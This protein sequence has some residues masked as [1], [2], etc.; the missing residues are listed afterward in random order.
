MSA[1]LVEVIARYNRI[2]ILVDANLLLLYFV[3]QLDPDL[4]SRFKRT[5]QFSREDFALLTLLLHRFSKI[6]TT[7]NILTEVSNLLGQLTGPHRTGLFAAFAHGITLLDEHYVPS[8]EAS[9]QDG[10]TRPG[11][12]DAGICRLVERRFPVL[13]DDLALAVRL[14]SLQVD[15]VN[16][17]DIRF[18]LPTAT[19]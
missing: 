5:Q 12:T 19:P 9:A 6:V 18:Q 17:N 10:F 1:P 15:V 2:G 3:G 7:P 11:L 14:R 13:T 4:V 8:T 16:F